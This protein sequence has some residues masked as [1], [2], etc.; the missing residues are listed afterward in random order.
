MH[1]DI[2]LIMTDEHF[3][4]LAFVPG[5]NGDYG[6]L[7][8]GTTMRNRLMCFRMWHPQRSL[9]PK[10]R[11]E[12]VDGHQSTPHD[13][14]PPSLEVIT[15]GGVSDRRLKGDTALRSPL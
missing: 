8:A 10:M 11:F 14:M 9:D 12:V 13:D 3:V 2:R 5:T 1:A 4:D 6:A 15:A 7:A